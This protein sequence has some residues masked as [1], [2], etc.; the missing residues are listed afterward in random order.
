VPRFHQYRRRPLDRR[1]CP[2][3]QAASYHDL[4]DWSLLAGVIEP[5]KAPS[6][7][8]LAVDDPG[9]AAVIF[10]R[11]AALRESLYRIFQCSLKNSRPPDADTAALRHELTIARAHQSLILEGNRYTWAFCQT[12]ASLDRVLWPIPLSA[13]DLLTSAQPPKLNQCPGDDCGWLFLDTSRTTPANGAACGIAAIAPKSSAFAPASRSYRARDARLR[14][15]AVPL[16]RTNPL[17]DQRNAFLVPHG[18]PQLRHHHLWRRRFHAVDQNRS[19]GFPCTTS[20]S[21][22]PEPCPADTGTL[23]SPSRIGSVCPASK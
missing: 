13:A 21:R 3:R 1:C 15:A 14:R 23:H 10:N 7:A 22:S 20:N 18:A 11:A 9:A 5:R 12:A 2:S 8:R 6:L 4:L 17:P 19:S 16:H